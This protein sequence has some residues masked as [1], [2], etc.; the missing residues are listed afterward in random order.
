MKRKY[1]P[2]I[3]H[4]A[5]AENRIDEPSIHAIRIVWYVWYV[6]AA[7]FYLAYVNQILILAEGT[8]ANEGKRE[9][10]RFPDFRYFDLEQSATAVL[11]SIG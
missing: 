11:I 6:F 3:F 4:R 7:Q 2:I 10:F 1:V 9:M 8:D 5:E